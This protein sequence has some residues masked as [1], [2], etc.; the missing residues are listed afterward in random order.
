MSQNNLTKYSDIDI[1]VVMAVKNEQIY[2]Q[3]AM[4]SI[5]NQTQ[6]SL[7]IIVIDDN[8][9]DLTYSIVEKLSKKHRNI[10]LYENTKSGKCSAFNYGISLAKGRFICIFA[11]DD[12]MPKDSLHARWSMIRHI[13]EN[14]PVVGLCKLTTLSDTKK[15]DGHIIPR[16][17]GAGALSGVSPLM[18]RLACSKIFPVPEILPNEDTW[19]ELAVLHLNDLKIIHSD[20]IGCNWRLHSGNSINMLVTYYEYN[21]KITSRM[22]AYTL[23]YQ[24]NKQYLTINQSNIL[25]EK[26]KCENARASGNLIGVIFSQVKFVEKLRA[27]S[28]TNSFFYNLRKQFYGLFSGW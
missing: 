22:R 13:P 27:I 19:M 10:F 4:E 14:S 8:S 5:I 17:K 20:I 6:V 1:S 12:V 21:K 7:E 23:F 24:M 3:E 2:I 18:N 28:I 26:I 11:G 9:T 15:L 16:A 25:F